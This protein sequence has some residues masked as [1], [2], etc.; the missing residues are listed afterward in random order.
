MKN[1]INSLS[2]TQLQGLVDYQKNRISQT[3][4][5]VIEDHL[6]GNSEDYNLFFG[7]DVKDKNTSENIADP[8][9]DAYLGKKKTTSGTKNGKAEEIEAGNDVPDAISRYLKNKKA[10]TSVNPYK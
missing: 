10:S 2:K 8:A 5:Y 9:I 3:M 7:Q 4:L 1:F 6:N